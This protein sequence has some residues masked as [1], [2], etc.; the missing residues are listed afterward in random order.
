MRWRWLGALLLVAIVG[1]IAGWWH[2]RHWR[3]ERAIFPVQGVEIGSDDSAEAGGDGAGVDWK[4]L[5]QI[6]AD[7][8]YIDASAS[9]FARDPAFSRNLEEARA[10]G[11]LV[12]A[13]HRYDPCQPADR[14]SANFVTIVPRDPKLLPPAIELVR[15]ADDCPIK[16]NDAAVESELM[17]FINQIETHTGKPSLLKVGPEFERRYHVAAT[18]DRT[19]WLMRDRFQPDYANRPWSMWTAN[20]QLQTT[21]QAEPVR[22]LVAQP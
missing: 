16:V 4:A 3:P 18:I 2:L 14:Q 9:A 15:L 11:L 5:K 7:F 13:V 8:A 1:G 20:S 19:L 10:A 12:G 17:T 6:G 22:W 21:A